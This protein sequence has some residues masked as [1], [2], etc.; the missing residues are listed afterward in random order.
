M[1]HTDS[2][3]MSDITGKGDACD[4]LRV[5]SE[6]DCACIPPTE[7]EVRGDNGTQAEEQAK[8]TKLSV[9]QDGE[10]GTPAHTRG[11]MDVVER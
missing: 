6:D 9:P 7:D 5:L 3:N 1:V 11:P 2:G 10:V 8:N 4:E